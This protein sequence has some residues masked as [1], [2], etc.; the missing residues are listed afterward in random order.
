MLGFYV[1]KSSNDTGLPGSDSLTPTH[2]HMGGY[3]TVRQVPGQVPTKGRPR[4]STTL[5]DTGGLW[6][7]TILIHPFITGMTN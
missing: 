3:P 6:Y 2:T 7:L 4:D 5:S 1:Y